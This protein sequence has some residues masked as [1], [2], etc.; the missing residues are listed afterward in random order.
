MRHSF[1]TLA[2]TIIVTLAAN[3]AVAGPFGPPGPPAHPVYPRPGPGPGPGNGWILPLVTGT[4]LGTV[5]ASQ[6]RTVVVGQPAPVQPVSPAPSTVYKRVQIY[7]PECNC[8]R[9][10]D[11]PVD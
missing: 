3:T 2:A 11:V 4:V 6:P 7:V 9:T 10:F 1:T 5:I 8:Y